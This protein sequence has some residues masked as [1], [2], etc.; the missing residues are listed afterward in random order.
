[1]CIDISSYHVHVCVFVH[2]CVCICVC[3]S[4][5]VHL[6]VCSICEGEYKCVMTYMEMRRH[7]RGAQSNF[8]ND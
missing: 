7:H 2:P 1:M 5:Y 4:V 6:C 3:A 8:L